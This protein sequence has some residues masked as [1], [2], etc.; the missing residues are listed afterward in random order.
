MHFNNRLIT[1]PVNALSLSTINISGIPNMAMTLCIKDSAIVLAHI[2]LSGI[3]TT[4][5]VYSQVTTK[6]YLKP[7]ISSGIYLTPADNLDIG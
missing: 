6:G 1:C 7:S 2:C 4:K 3:A 5:F